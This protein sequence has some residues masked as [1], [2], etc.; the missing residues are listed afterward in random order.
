MLDKSA[1]LAAQDLKTET[2]SV[3]EWSGDVLVRTLTAAA[4]EAYSSSLV[5]ADGKPNGSGF[6]VKLLVR[7][8]VDEAGNRVF[9]DEDADLLEAKSSAAIERVFKV[10]DRLNQISTAAIDQAEKN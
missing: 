10:A 2:V 5:G 4:R 7:C 6:K 9:G 1:I 8:I 3:P